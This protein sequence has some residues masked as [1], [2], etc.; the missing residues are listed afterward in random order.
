MLKTTG[1]VDI[2]SSCLISIHPLFVITRTSVC[3]GWQHAQFL[4]KQTHYSLSPMQL[5]WG[6]GWGEGRVRLLGD[7]LGSLLSSYWKVLFSW[8]L[9]CSLSLLP[10]LP[11]S[12]SFCLK[13]GWEAGCRA[14]ALTRMW[15]LVK[16]KD[17]GNLSTWWHYGACIQPQVLTRVRNLYL[18]KPFVVSF[19]FHAGKTIPICY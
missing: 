19:L 7:L 12:P 11:P 10:P 9:C 4:K 18:I 6:Q 1:M 14:P 13:Q 3:L 16:Q 15:I 2:A 5:L 8:Y 17:R